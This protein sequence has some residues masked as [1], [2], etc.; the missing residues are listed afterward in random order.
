MPPVVHAW[1]EPEMLVGVEAHGYPLERVVGFG[2]FG[3]VY[4]TKGSQ[5]EPRAAKVLYPP[6]SR[7]S[8]DLRAWANRAAHFLR[9]VQIVAHFD[10][11]NIIRIYDTG[12]LYWRFDD[13]L[14]GQEGH[15]DRSGDYLLPFYVTEYIP[16]GL[17]QH[18]RGDQLFDPK[19]AVGIGVQICDGLAELH[20]SNP[21]VLHRD[22]NPGNIRLA[23]GRRAVITD[24][25]V[26][27][28]LDVPAGKVTIEIIPPDVAAPEQLAGQEPDVR[29]D[30]Y[31]VGA[32]LLAMLTGK[33]PREVELSNLLN[34]KGV[35]KDLAR[36]IHRCLAV[37][38]ERRFPDVASLR[39]ALLE[40]RLS[41]PRRL[42]ILPARLLG[43][44]VYRW[45]V[46]QAAGHV[47][48][49]WRKPAFWGLAFPL[50]AIGSLAWVLWPPEPINITLANSSVKKEWIDWAIQD[51]NAASKT[52]QNLQLKGRP[53]A[54]NGT[55]IK[56]EVIFE[57]IGPG[58][59]DH[60]RSGTMIRD[61]LDSKIKPTIASPAERSWVLNLKE[62]WPGGEAI[63]KGEAPDLVRT[64][65]VIAMWESRAT[66][67]G[68][69]PR[70]GPDCTWRRLRTLGTS[71][72]GWGTLGHPEW[73]RWKFGYGHVGRSNS[74][75]FTQ[76]LNCFSGLHKTS[77]LTVDEVRIGTGCGQAMLDVNRA[78]PIIHEKSETVCTWLRERGPSFLDGCTSYEKEIIEN[79]LIYGPTLPEPI[80]AVYP[81]DGTI[82]AT[83]PFA[84]LDGAPWV[85][86]EQAEAAA[87]FLRFLLSDQQQSRLKGHGFRPTDPDLL[88]GPP[89]DPIN[90]ANPRAN[91]VVV[92]V[93][94]TEVIDAVVQLWTCI[95]LGE[96]P[97]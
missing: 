19:E 64:P 82:V 34:A 2:G 62:T 35:P 23:E 56:V 43:T 21:R 16:D 7:S 30:I 91:L 39:T 17:D 59:R 86:S 57:E 38:R 84:V 4:L 96:C 97:R 83:H 27:R 11:K 52:D 6:H 72:D 12:Y 51:F 69:W 92:E 65:L 36:V 15:Q 68:C 8:E 63:M 46:E 18:V 40:A 71:P 85:T 10:H 80:V 20:G 37:D 76:A 32:L 48:P 26:A 3:A 55:P 5:G 87:V 14:R 31:Q 53:L 45:L 33:F 81:Q 74:A 54:L 88:L 70:A 22:L 60:Y 94:G 73:G 44:S 50:A 42:F 41:P 67:L 75:T 77:G 25:G 78:A 58:L 89:I 29:T 24:F 79:N 49:V 61:I 66:A 93:P 1:F 90:G 9:E 47:P 13:P 95:R 28:F